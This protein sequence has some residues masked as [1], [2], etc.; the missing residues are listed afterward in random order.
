ML[1]AGI[2]GI[3]KEID[4]TKAGFGPINEDILTLSPGRR[5]QIKS[6]P[7]CLESAMDALEKDNQFLIKSNVFNWEMI[8][9]WIHKKRQEAY[10][11][12][13]RPH[14]YEIEQYFGV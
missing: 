13:I 7:R 2:D 9:L 10:D 4:P 5:K 12:S 1:L 14:P 8:D 11:I 6:L 3:E